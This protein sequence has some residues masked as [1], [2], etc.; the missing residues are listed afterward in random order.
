MFTTLPILLVILL[1][2]QFIYRFRNYDIE[3]EAIFGSL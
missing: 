3:K 2:C 1:A